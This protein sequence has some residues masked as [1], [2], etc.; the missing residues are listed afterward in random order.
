MTARH[1]GSRKW[2]SHGAEGW[3]QWPRGL[4]CR[5][6]SLGRWDH[7]FKSCLRHRYL[8]SS[9]HHHS[10]VSLSSMPYG[11]V[12]EKA[13]LNKYKRTK[14]QLSASRW[15]ELCG[16]AC[17]TQV[18]FYTSFLPSSIIVQS[19]TRPWPTRTLEMSLIYLDTP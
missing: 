14:E 15:V 8:S 7:G 6:W 13:S 2:V 16:S 19:L 12:T 5:P 4:R 1:H 9:T 18:H 17:S 10:L 3:S 11:L